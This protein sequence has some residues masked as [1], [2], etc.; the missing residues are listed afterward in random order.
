MKTGLFWV[1]TQRVVVIPY[2]RLYRNVGKKVIAQKSV[3]FSYEHFC[4]ISLRLM[5]KYKKYG[6][7]RGWRN[8]WTSKYN[9]APQMRFACRII[10]TRLKVTLRLFPILFMQRYA[11]GTHR[12]KTSVSQPMR[13]ETFHTTRICIHIGELETCGSCKRTNYA[14]TLSTSF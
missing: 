1:I 5:G 4:L 9:M 14:T 10:R 11:V 2:R 3:V 8:S 7:G 12:D 6:K 13:T